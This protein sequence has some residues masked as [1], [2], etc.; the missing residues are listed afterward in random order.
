[1]WWKKNVSINCL[2]VRRPLSDFTVKCTDRRINV[3]RNQKPISKKW[4][5]RMRQKCSLQVVANLCPISNVFNGFY[6]WWW[7]KRN[8]IHACLNKWRKTKSIGYMK[9]VNR[10][11]K[12][13]ALNAS[14]CKWCAS[15]TLRE[16]F[17]HGVHS[18]RI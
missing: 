10:L 12:S 8:K 6:R 14:L 1:M 9:S 15:H 18:N 4:E 17:F 13:T 3:Y 7:K 16:P 2:F 11:T 5:N